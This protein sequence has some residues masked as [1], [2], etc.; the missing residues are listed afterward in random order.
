MLD[1]LPPHAI[2]YRVW[3]IPPKCLLLWLWPATLTVFFF[4]FPLLPFLFRKKK[5]NKKYYY[6][7][8]TIS[9]L[10]LV[11][12][13]FS[14]KCVAHGWTQRFGF[15]LDHSLAFTNSLRQQLFFFSLNPDFPHRSTFCCESTNSSATDT[16]QLFFLISKSRSIPGYSKL[17]TWKVLFACV[18]TVKHPA[19]SP[20][21]PEPLFHEYS[22]WLYDLCACFSRPLLLR[23][24][25]WTNRICFSPSDLPLF[26]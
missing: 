26:L 12:R 10:R 15:R 6:F 25:D 21:Y 9:S 11:Y 20:L 13:L 24:S 17:T 3:I 1:W 2:S 14:C 19:R 16:P 7:N 22:I 23:N 18:H 8:Q 4:F 5:E